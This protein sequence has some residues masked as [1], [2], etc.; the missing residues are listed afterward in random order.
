MVLLVK[1]YC[2]S[3]YTRKKVDAVHMLSLQHAMDGI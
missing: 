2:C 3:P 1:E